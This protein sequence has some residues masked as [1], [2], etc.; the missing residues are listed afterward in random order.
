M[1]RLGRGCCAGVRKQLTTTQSGEG[2]HH[3]GT[4]R[5]SVNLSLSTESADNA[6]S[7]VGN[8]SRRG[9]PLWPLCHCRNTGC[10]RVAPALPGCGISSA[11]GI[12]SYMGCWLL[13]SDGPV[14][15]TS[16]EG[17]REVRGRMHSRNARRFPFINGK[18]PTAA[19]P[20]PIHRAQ[21]LD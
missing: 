16:W 9:T 15:G 3:A 5:Q 12:G 10:Y 2:W 17:I 19:P 14:M 8:A 13:A 11:T 4:R 18:H 1:V 6:R 21:G 20:R 7:R